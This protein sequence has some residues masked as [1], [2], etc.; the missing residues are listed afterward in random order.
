MRTCPV[1]PVLIGDEDG[2]VTMWCDYRDDNSCH[3]SKGLGYGPNF[4]DV[5][6][7]RE[8]HKTRELLEAA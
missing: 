1:E 2:D 8:V 6:E 7:A 3:W 4:Y 5:L